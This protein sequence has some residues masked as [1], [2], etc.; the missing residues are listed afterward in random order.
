MGRK[1]T[2]ET[3]GVC[4]CATVESGGKVRLGTGVQI[5]GE[6]GWQSLVL[7]RI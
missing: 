6:A 5:R 1:K 4:V 7:S 2:E 3:A